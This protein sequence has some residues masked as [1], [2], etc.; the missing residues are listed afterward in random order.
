MPVAILVLLHIGAIELL[1]SLRHT[2]DR[3]PVEVFTQL[4]TV[5]PKT[6]DTA[7]AEAQ[8]LPLPR[9]TTPPAMTLAPLPVVPDAVERAREPPAP[10]TLPET[11]AISVGTPS[12]GAAGPLMGGDTGRL[13][14]GIPKE[15][16]THPPP[17]TAAQEAMRDPRSNKLVL[18]KQE[19]I[20][21]DFGQ[22]ECIAW[23]REPD[24]SIYRG[25]GHWKRVVPAP[26][27]GKELQECVK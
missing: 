27:G 16:F 3:S 8:R 6:A 13:K 14:L 21:I 20:E 18:T 5:R 26:V 25:P 19:Q 24:G 4:F 7:P 11:G 17:L 10:A 15:F 1:L 2:V 22:I 12:S 23:Q 9:A